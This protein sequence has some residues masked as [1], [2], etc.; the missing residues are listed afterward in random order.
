M[1]SIETGYLEFAELVAIKELPTI[2]RYKK[3]PVAIAE[4]IQEIPCNPCEASCKLGAI[5]IG[6]P[7]T[8]M[9]VIDYDKCK[10]C[11]VCISKCSGLAIFVIDKSYSDIK[12][13]VAFAYEY[14]PTPS[15]GQKVWGTDRKGQVICEAEVV[16]VINLKSFDHTPIVTIEIPINLVDLVRGVKL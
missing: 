12:A 5:T 9:P 14:F 6:Q 15:E 11:K 10:G 3:G 1:L 4:C 8:N 7:I 13:T 2:E 16:K